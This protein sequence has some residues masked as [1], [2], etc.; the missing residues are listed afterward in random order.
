MIGNIRTV[1]WL[2]IV[3]LFLPFFGIPNNWKTLMA[4]GIGLILIILAF[5]M[6]KQYRAVRSVIRNLEHTVAE[7]TLHE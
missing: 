7:K 1:F 6:R 3:M 2:G 5:M 4:V